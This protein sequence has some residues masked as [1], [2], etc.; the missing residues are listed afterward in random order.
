MYTYKMFLS[1]IEKSVEVRKGPFSL[2]SRKKRLKKP[3]RFLRGIYR[4]ILALSSVIVVLYLVMLVVLR[5]PDVAQAV[6]PSKDS[7]EYESPIVKS[8]GDKERRELCY[9]FLLLAT[10]DGNGNTDTIMLMTYDIV[11]QKI[12]MVS[13]PRDTVVETSRRIPK[14]N[15]AYNQGIDVVRKE[16][17]NLVGFP[18]DFYVLVDMDAFVKL[19]D[20]VGGL[21]FNVPVEMYYDDPTQDLSIHYMPGKQ[22]LN[23]KQALEVAR[24]RQNGDETGYVDSDVGRTETQQKLIAVLAKKV[25]SWNSLTKVNQFVD[26]FSRYVETDLTGRDLAYFASEAVKIDTS[27]GFATATLPGDGTKRYKGF[28]WCYDL[29]QEESL[30]M[31]NELLNP[32]TEDLTI[33]DPHFVDIP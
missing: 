14:I 12:G 9:T 17:S 16:V 24:F 30:R 21:E 2:Q 5:P 22:F 3:Y 33:E 13:I 29:E 4:T 20:A 8:Q 15:A 28:A 26:I 18:I 31:L 27:G 23:G 7:T 32:Y 19:V 11:N 6:Q 1:K 10:D 25:I